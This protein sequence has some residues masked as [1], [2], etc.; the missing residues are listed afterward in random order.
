MERLVFGLVVLYY[1]LS[2]I[3]ATVQ[4]RG[5]RKKICKDRV[6]LAW[7]ALRAINMTWL[8]PHELMMHALIHTRWSLNYETG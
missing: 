1:A 3:G 4:Q 6:S 2:L 8:L 7:L 5:L